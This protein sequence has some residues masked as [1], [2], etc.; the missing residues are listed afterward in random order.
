MYRQFG[1]RWK[2]VLVLAAMLGASGVLAYERQA[3][4]PADPFLLVRISSMAGFTNAVQSLPI[5]RLW[6]N[7]QFQNFLGNPDINALLQELSGTNAVNTEKAHLES[8]IW[9]LFQGEV[10]MAFDR[11][12]EGPAS[13]ANKNGGET[14]ADLGMDLTYS[15]IAQCSVENHRK[16]MELEQRLADLEKGRVSR[17][18]IA[19]QGYEIIQTVEP[20]ENGG[21]TKSWQACAGGFLLES[22]RREWVEGALA[23]IKRDGPPAPGRAETPCIEAA[24]SGAKIRKSLEETISEFNMPDP[25]E[26]G[27]DAGAQEEKPIGPAAG[28]PK[29][30]AP[31]VVKALGLDTLNSIGMTIRLEPAQVSMTVAVDRGPARN[32]I[33]KLIDAQP[34]PGDAKLPYAPADTVSFGV[35]RANYPALWNEIPVV[36]R[37]IDPQLEMMFGMMQAMTGINVASDITPHLDTLLLSLNDSKDRV[38]LAVQLKNAAA[39]SATLKR[40]LGAADPAAPTQR[41]DLGAKE[42]EFRGVQLYVWQPAAGDSMAVAV[43][44]ATLYVGAPELVRGVIRAQTAEKPVEDAFFNTAI[45]RNMLKYKPDGATSYQL[46]DLPSAIRTMLRAE[47]IEKAKLVLA[48]KLIK[49]E[50]ENDSPALKKFLRGID[51]SK[52]PPADQIAAFFGPMFGY[53]SCPGDR[54]ELQW[55]VQSP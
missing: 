27:Q 16:I 41:P 6:K 13:S 50:A 8:E 52:M 26:S 28:K 39:M 49:L 1:I 38:L 19:F 31:A 5:G 54:I 47:N 18:R 34:A 20:D 24:F 53:A 15:A 43:A 14:N 12:P 29:I 45:Y 4:L 23:R 48:A 11:D 30:D 51:F 10:I 2:S 21:E 32:G 37:T 25:G 7:A 36:L 42:E 35:A 40:L 55:L 44:G 17:T 33:W 9:R 46:M 3:L 22:D